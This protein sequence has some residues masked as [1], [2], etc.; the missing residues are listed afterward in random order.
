M[1]A[2]VLFTTP[3]EKEGRRA[4]RKRTESTLRMTRVEDC[5]WVWEWIVF[6]FFSSCPSRIFLRSGLAVRTSIWEALTPKSIRG[7]RSRRSGDSAAC[8][9]VQQPDVAPHP[10]MWRGNRTHPQLR[11]MRACMHAWRRG[12]KHLTRGRVRSLVAWRATQ[13]FPSSSNM[14]KELRKMS[15]LIKGVIWNHLTSPRS[16]HK[17]CSSP[18]SMPQFS[19][20]FS[21]KC[22]QM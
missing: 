6:P 13:C 9:H 14:F 20:N 5:L 16:A 18:Q 8:A 12:G 11:C 19:Q 3:A 7:G 17:T 2:V 1:M 10:C 15:V 22:P 4:K 21:Y